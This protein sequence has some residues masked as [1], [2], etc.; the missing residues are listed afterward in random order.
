L[1]LLLQRTGRGLLSM[2]WLQLRWIELGCALRRHP[3]TVPNRVQYA[4]PVGGTVMVDEWHTCKCA[5]RSSGVART[6]TLRPYQEHTG[7]ATE[8]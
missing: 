2:R 1:F 6:R 4:G 8:R 3:L 7:W 5:K